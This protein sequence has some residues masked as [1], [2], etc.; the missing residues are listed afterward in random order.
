M[1]QSLDLI[2]HSCVYD[3]NIKPEF[4][5]LKNWKS[6]VSHAVKPGFMSKLKNPPMKMVCKEYWLYW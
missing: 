5:S 6:R 3:V 4:V 1:K 2:S